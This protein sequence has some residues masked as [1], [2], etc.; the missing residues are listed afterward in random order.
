MRRGAYWDG[1]LETFHAAGRAGADLL[2][3]ESTGGKEVCDEALTQAD[4]RA[5]VFALGVLAPRDMAFL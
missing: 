1:M 5:L 3:I 2:A 4:L